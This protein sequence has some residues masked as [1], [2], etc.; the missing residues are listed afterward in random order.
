MREL[1]RLVVAHEHR[2]VERRHRPRL[3]ID[4]RARPRM[5]GRELERVLALQV[6]EPDIRDQHGQRSNGRPA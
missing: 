2:P 1:V 3:R 5:A 6:L 4:V